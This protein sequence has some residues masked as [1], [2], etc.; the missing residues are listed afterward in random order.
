MIRKARKNPMRNN[1][2]L[3]V[4][5][6]LTIALIMMGLSSI[7]ALAYTPPEPGQEDESTT[8]QAVT[9]VTTWQAVT[10][11]PSETPGGSAEQQATPAALTP[12]GNMAL[13][14]DVSGEQSEDKQ[15]ITV[16]TKS[17]NYFYIVIDRAADSEN[18]HFMNLVDEADLMALMEGEQATAPAIIEPPAPAEPDEE[19]PAPEP[20]KKN[21][22]GAILGAVVILALLGGGALFYLKVLKPKKGAAGGGDIIDFGDLDEYGTDGLP[23]EDKDVG[24][25]VD[26]AYAEPGDETDRDSY[27]Y[28]EDEE[29]QEERL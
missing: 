25:D 6:A 1:K 21:G 16:V 26:D 24:A 17:G 18:V 3:R 9:E 28:R 29:R 13:V 20:E 4:S 8:G 19:E 23:Y 27:T 14:D 5:C 2:Y 11:E 12:G 10:G 7:M 15:F 22:L